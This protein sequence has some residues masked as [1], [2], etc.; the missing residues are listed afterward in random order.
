MIKITRDLALEFGKF[1]NNETIVKNHELLNVSDGCELFWTYEN[2]NDLMELYYT[3]EYIK[4]NNIKDV[5]L[6]ICY[7]PYS[8]MDRRNKDYGFTLKYVSNL[9]NSM[10]FSKVK[11]LEPHSDVT[12]ALLNNSMA[13]SPTKYFVDKIKVE[14]G[15]DE[16]KDFIFYPD[17]GA[18]KRYEDLY[19]ENKIL[20]GFKTRDFKTGN[21]KSLDI[22]GNIENHMNKV[23]IID[24]LCSKGGTFILSAD[25]LKKWGFNEIYLYTTHCEN[26]IFDGYIPE[27]KLIDK[28]FTTDSLLK[29]DSVCE[30]IHVFK[31]LEHQ[32]LF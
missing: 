17:T 29:T 15:F 26:T 14:I 1:P 9:I 16:E 24:D 6:Y 3:S 7:M 5:I 8:R 25:R 32:H 11:V 28:V 31:I 23:I 30:K 4:E 2:D 18:F 21:I 19:P 13:I 27:T 12:C 20:C 10:N 22:L